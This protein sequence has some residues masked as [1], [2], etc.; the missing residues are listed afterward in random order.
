[1][2]ETTRASKP[3][4][5]RAAGSKT[6]KDYLA[7]LDELTRRNKGGFS[8]VAEET[9]SSIPFML[10]GRAV[11]SGVPE[12]PQRQLAEL[13][14]PEE[15]QVQPQEQLPEGQVQ[16]A[17]SQG[18]SLS[19][20]ISQLNQNLG[21]ND[22]LYLSPTGQSGDGGA[23]LS[24]G[25]TVYADGSVVTKDGQQIYATGSIPGGGL[26]FSD[27]S[28]KFFDSSLA[29]IQGFTEGIFGEILDVTQPYGNVNPI[30][31]SPGNINTG[32]DLR[33]KN[34]ASKAFSLPVETQVLEVLQDDG[35]RFGD[36]SGHQGYGNSVLLKLPTGEVVRL[37]HLADIGDFQVGASIPAGTYVGTTGQTG[38]TYGE[39]L[40]VEYYN[41]DGQLSDLSTFSGF[42]Q[43]EQLKQ[44]VLPTIPTSN[45]PQPMYQSKPVSQDQ[46]S[47]MTKLQEAAKALGYSPDTTTYTPKQRSDVALTSMGFNPQGTIGAQ[48]L[49][50]GDLPAAG[51][52]LSQTIERVNPT[53][54][55]DLGI[56]EA[57]RGDMAGAKQQ[58]ASTAGRV[59]N[60]LA[61]I[62]GQIKDAIVNPAYAAEGNQE[63]KQSLGENLQY[64]GNKVS[65][66]VGAK[67]GEGIDKLK[68]VFGKGGS[69]ANLFS[70][71]A[72]SSIGQQRA[73]GEQ[74]SSSSLLP[75]S[76]ADA[77]SQQ[78]ASGKNDIRDPF[79]KSGMN[80]RY[81]VQDTNNGALSLDMFGPE[82]FQNPENIKSVLGG[83]QFE[84]PATQKYQAFVEEQR[85]QEEAR[86][87]AEQNQNNNGGGNN[88]GNNNGGSNNSGSQSYNSPQSN[89][90][91]ANYATGNIGQQLSQPRQNSQPTPVYQPYANTQNL[92]RQVSQ[93]QPTP[94]PQQNIFQKA[95]SGV[96]N[97][98]KKWFQ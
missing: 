25:S 51:R 43:P 26:L 9:G 32:T 74:G 62:P 7:Q 88:N 58:F 31:P 29:G 64:M 57:L 90:N 92:M 35:T 8:A 67:A 42:S 28:K 86:R 37:S 91:V 52:E 70:K 16:G 69:G 63:P 56:S 89:N 80:E 97:L 53:P 75:T 73:V 83:T 6:V 3:I 17:Q 77:K 71:P 76:F 13:P 50:A 78:A 84:A 19:D 85:R 15:Y 93:S 39:H 48:E 55:L 66:Y 33:T 68:S 18:T 12:M 49:L 34:L 22:S 5:S 72:M 4:F 94:Q 27:G 61:Q 59:G 41:V 98:F 10:P 82:F 23:I 30:E 45:E 95:A 21:S 20:F 65:E 47:G 96:S 11:K 14:Q 79:F 44:Y 38:N 24:D 1:M 46:P 60:R 87:Q 40:D 2:A 36:K 81:G 54:R